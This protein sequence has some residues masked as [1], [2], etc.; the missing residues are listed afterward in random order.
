M[1]NGS[2]RGVLKWQSTFLSDISGGIHCDD[3]Y[4]YAKGY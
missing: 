2:I 3:L 4:H 1:P